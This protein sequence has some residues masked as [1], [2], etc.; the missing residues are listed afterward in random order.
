M[1]NKHIKMNSIE[2]F[3]H[4]VHN[5]TK[6]SAF[7]EMI[8]GEPVFDYLKPKP[9][10]RAHGTVKLH[11]TCAMASANSEDIWFQSKSN[12]VTI[13]KDN[14]GFA[15]FGNAKIEVF[16]ELIEK[17]KTEYC[18]DTTENIITILGE[19]CGAG[20][21]KGVAI[22]E[23]P[24]MFVIFGVKISP[25]DEEIPAYWVSNDFL[26][27]NENNIYNIDDFETFDIEVDFNNPEI[28]QNKMVE[29][30]EKVDKECPVGKA[31]GKIGHGEGVVW[32]IVYQDTPM[33]W[34]VK[35]ESH[36][37]SNVRVTKPKDLEKLKK[38]D[39]CV[40]EI[41][42]EWRFI[43]ALTE[44]FGTEYERDIDRKK[45]GEYMKWVSTDTIKEEYD[46]IEKHGFDPKDVMGRVQKKAKDFFF[47][48][49]QL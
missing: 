6:Q 10:L 9:V 19:W 29:I 25:L 17:V 16:K 40:E 20:I 38:I 34:K 4:V 28:A 24:K 45:L 27:S 26:K 15:A 39:L 44:V 42:H 43:Q 41:T 35:G 37:K 30:T 21:Q 32:E 7:V 5:I 23:L 8:D 11:G 36:S 22:T 13:G 47:A 1:I 3:R 12:I 31:F 33:K 18:I 46:I 14:A 49:E 48:V 2:Q